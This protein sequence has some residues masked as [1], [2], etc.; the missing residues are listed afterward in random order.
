M[1]SHLPF[2]GAIL[3]NP[4]KVMSFYENVFICFEWFC[5]R[6]LFYWILFVINQIGL[7]SG[8]VPRPKPMMTLFPTHSHY[9]PLSLTKIANPPSWLGYGLHITSRKITGCS[10][11]PV[12]NFR[13]WMNSC[14][15]LTHW[16]R[17]THICIA[18]RTII[19]SDNGLSPG[20][21]Q[22]IIWTIAGILLIGPLGINFSEMLIGVQIFS[23]KKMYSK[24]SSEKWLP[25]CLGLNVLNLWVYYI[26]AGHAIVVVK[27]INLLFYHGN[28]VILTLW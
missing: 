28:A 8:L 10:Y 21:R 20:R 19:G 16:G 26:M 23:F 14:I 13:V 1:L 5:Q 6:I 2:Q 17:V 25:F 15:L 18:K 9:G 3:H 12:L 11:L 22:A 7:D 27:D 24:M 4:T